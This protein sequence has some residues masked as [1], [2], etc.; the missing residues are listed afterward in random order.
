MGSYLVNIV[1]ALVFIYEAFILFT[2]KN[3]GSDRNFEKYTE[4]SLAKFS[5]IGGVVLLLIAVYEVIE[6]LHRAN[7]I[8]FIP[9]DEDGRFPVYITVPVLVVFIVAYLLLYFVM[10]KKKDGYTDSKSGGNSSTSNKSDDDE[11]F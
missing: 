9:L 11:E 2:K 3:G 4:E 6:F 8:Q 5:P 10:L 7:I 1:L